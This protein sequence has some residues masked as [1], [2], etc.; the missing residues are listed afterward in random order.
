MSAILFTEP[1][2]VPVSG[3]ATVYPGAKLNFY[4]TGTSTRQNTYTDSAL[5]VA[6]ANP[7]VADADGRFAPIYLDESLEHYKVVLTDSADVTLY[8]VDPISV[9]N[10]GSVAATMSALLSKSTSLGTVTVDGYHA[11]ADGGGGVFYW[12]SAQDKANHNGG[13][14]IDPDITFPTTW[15]TTSEQTTWFT[16][17]SGTGAWVR[18]EGKYNAFHFGATGDGSTDDTQPIQQLITATGD[19]EILAGS[20]KITNILTMLDNTQLTLSKNAVLTFSGTMLT[21]SMFSATSKSNVHIT[22]GQMIGDVTADA[23]SDNTYGN[24]INFVS[25]SNVSVRDTKISY[26]PRAGIH[27]N[28]TT[29]YEIISNEIH[30]IQPVTTNMTGM[31]GLSIEDQCDNGIIQHNVIHDI[32]KYT[33]L[34]S[35]GSGIRIIVQTSGNISKNFD[36]SHNYIYNIQE[37]GITIYDGVGSSAESSSITNNRIVDTGRRG[38]NGETGQRGNG[39]YLLKVVGVSITNN[40]LARTNTYTSVASIL[41]A[42]ISV[43]ETSSG[44]E[45]VIISGNTIQTDPLSGIRVQGA[46]TAVIDG[47][48]INAVSDLIWL[49]DCDDFIISN[50]VCIGSGADLGIRAVQ[51]ST[52]NTTG[53]ITG[54]TVRNTTTA[55]TITNTVDCNISNNT[56]IEYDT[57]GVWQTASHNTQGTG[58]VI[59]SSADVP[60]LIISDNTKSITAVA[61]G[62]TGYIEV[63]TSAAHGL[64]VSQTIVISGTTDY[65][66]TYTITSS[67]SNT[68]FIVAATYVSSQ[69]GTVTANNAN[70]FWKANNFKNRTGYNGPYIRNNGTGTCVH[71][72]GG[73][74]PNNGTY[75]IGDKCTFITPASGSPDYARCIIAG[76]P[77]GTNWKY[78]GNLT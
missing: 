34:D 3:S 72:E 12:D 68:T 4:E 9:T 75:A 63:T 14:V 55:I 74:I 57:Y 19:I 73:T 8:T 45:P 53:S 26:F 33:T 15:A 76:S 51:N 5:S 2:F 48:T 66:D 67:A 69:T 7:V 17:G 6:H 16:A 13:S 30:D 10:S 36:V 11:A 27:L 37:H 61:A 35:T 42:A 78:G 1:S 24:A 23:D 58:N 38:N 47:N 50:N 56:I 22:G 59:N 32:G 52:V 39:I 62:D 49:A 31:C 54:N 41:H 44:T 65:N 64:G 28:S 70:G 21:K 29:N 77:S 20:Y 43:A 40:S 71:F 18:A 46:N 25:C 60:D